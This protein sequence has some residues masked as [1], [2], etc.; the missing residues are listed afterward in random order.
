MNGL[1]KIVLESREHK[2]WSV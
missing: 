1:K 2:I